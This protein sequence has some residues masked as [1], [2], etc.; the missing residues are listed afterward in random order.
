MKGEQ[1]V[2]G[3]P[4]E[5]NPEWTAEDFR[6]AKSFAEVFPDLAE[7]IK[8]GRGPQKA[9][10]KKMVTLRLDVDVVERFRASGKGWQSRVNA[11]LAAHAP[12]RRRAGKTA[13]SPARARLK[14]SA[15]RPIASGRKEKQ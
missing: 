13:A 14:K 5:E 8:R 6:T 7:K 2:Y 12:R 1:P 11:L 9:P 4:D 10:T 3:V 15:A